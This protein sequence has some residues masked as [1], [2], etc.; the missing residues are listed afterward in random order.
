MVQINDN[1]DYKD[2]LEAYNSRIFLLKKK[3][4]LHLIHE[5]NFV[6]GG[7]C[8]YVCLFILGQELKKVQSV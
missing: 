8:F 5:V 6:H 2:N 7:E 1:L 3:V 4:C